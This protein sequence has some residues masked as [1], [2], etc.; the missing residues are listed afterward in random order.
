MSWKKHCTATSPTNTWNG[1]YRIAL[2]KSRQKAT[3]TTLQK[4]DGTIT[5]DMGETLTVI[6]EQLTLE[7]NTLDDTEYHRAIRR[8]AE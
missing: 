2:G 5:A 3:M 7:D 8:L 6:L 4:P 1:I